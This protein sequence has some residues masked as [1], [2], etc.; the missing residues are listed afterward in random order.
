M[1]SPCRDN[2]LELKEMGYS[3]RT[4][5][6]SSSSSPSS[7]SSSLSSFITIIIIYHHRHRPAERMRSRIT[8]PTHT[9]QSLC[10]R[11]R[12][13]LPCK[14]DDTHPLPQPP[15]VAGYVFSPPGPRRALMTAFSLLLRSPLPRRTTGW[16]ETQTTPSRKHFQPWSCPARLRPIAAAVEPTAVDVGRGLLG[17]PLGRHRLGLAPPPLPPV[18]SVC[19]V[20]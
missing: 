9:K 7:S 11:C 15:I 18:L 13:D 14:H 20:G 2:G 19:P 12:G 16:A 5:S 3:V 10:P 17:V 1:C 8:I 6:S 4:S